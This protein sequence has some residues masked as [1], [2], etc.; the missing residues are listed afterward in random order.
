MSNYSKNLS[1]L[2]QKLIVANQIEY[3]DE[4]SIRNFMANAVSGE[5]GVYLQ[6]GSL[7]TGALSAGDVFKIVQMRDG[8]VEATPLIKWD[9][10]FRSLYTAY[11]APVRQVSYIGYAA[12]GSD[13][14]SFNFTGAAVDNALTAGISVRDTTPGNQPFPVQEGYATITSS[15]QDEY[16][17]LAQIVSAL[18]GDYDYER[19][20]PDR[21]VKA[22]IV[23]NGALTELTE[24]ATVINGSTI[25]TFAGNQTIATGAFVAFRGIV[26]KVAVGVSAGTSLTIDRPYQGASETF[27][28]SASVDL[29]ATIAYTSG[30]T[31]LGVKLT[32]LSDE[33]HFKITGVDNLYLS[34]ITYTTAWKLGSGSGASIVEWEK[35]EGIIFDGVGSTV[36]AAFKDDFGQPTLF[37][38]SSLTYNLMFLDFSP[39]ILPSAGLP[40]Y[41]QNQ[42]ERVVFAVPASGTNPNAE[43]RTIF[44]L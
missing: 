20:Q 43:L 41:Q 22:E 12:T 13:D 40:N 2:N 38:S 28:V 35:R 30:T 18:N 21:F 23:S 14:L 4:T 36:N 37:G 19:T 34:P 26:Y 27:D 1:G 17:T 15:T 5:I 29:A 3:T 31:K 7:Q 9:D 33:C 11:V 10:L 39:G 8:F 6:D 16:E 24:D 32:G 25:V 44:G 42:I